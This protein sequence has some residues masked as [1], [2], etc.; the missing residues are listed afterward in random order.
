MYSVVSFT[1]TN[2]VDVVA[3]K[4][5]FSSGDEMLCYWPSSEKATVITKA[6][7]ACLTAEKDWTAYPCRVLYQTGK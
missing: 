3:S 7:R 5:I 4:W 6:V 1:S 2:D